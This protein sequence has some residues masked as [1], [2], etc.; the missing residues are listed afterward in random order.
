MG[1]LKE[2]TWS[3]AFLD[4]LGYNPDEKTIT[5]TRVS[6]WYQTDLESYL[7][8]KWITEIIVAGVAT[9]LAVSST[10]RDA[11]DRDITTTIISDACATV[12]EEHHEAALIGIAKLVSVK[13]MEEFLHL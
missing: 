10:A 8:E 7:K 11:H 5:K 13:K 4:A 3:V 9:D 1:I 2:N 12:S 6:P